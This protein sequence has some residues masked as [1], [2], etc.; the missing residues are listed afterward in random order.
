VLLTLMLALLLPAAVQGE[1]GEGQSVTAF[2]LQASNG[3]E[4]DAM[5][6]GPPE[7]DEESEKED[8]GTI[9][10]VL[11][12]GRHFIVS[13]AA[14]ATVTETTIDADL[15]KLGK[16]SVT[17][18]PTGRTR[19]V[20]LGCKPGS[21]KQVEVEIE[22]YE[23]TIEFHGEEGFTEVSATSAPLDYPTSIICSAGDAGGGSDQDLHELPGARLHA[24]KYFHYQYRLEF[25]AVQNRPGSRVSVNA[26]VEEHRGEME[27]HRATWLQARAGVLRYDRRLRSATVKPPAP[28]AGHATFHDAARRRNRWTGNLTVDFPGNADVPVTGPGFGALLEHPYR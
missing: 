4:L 5:A 8:K 12:G 2:R 11:F 13:Y 27:I 3:Y 7:G 16:I 19:T 18:V 10:L 9:L 26:E 6:F 20:R 14:P 22:R 21:T 23:G 15:G 28:F 25:D 1:E 17:R 24:E